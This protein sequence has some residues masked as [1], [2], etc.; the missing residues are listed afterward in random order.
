MPGTHFTD[1]PDYY[2]VKPADPLRRIRHMRS[3]FHWH[4]DPTRLH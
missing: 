2:P 4:E 3:H 1:M